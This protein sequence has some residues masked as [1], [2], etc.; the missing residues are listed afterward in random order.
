MWFRSTSQAPVR[1]SDDLNPSGIHS[2]INQVELIESI[3]TVFLVP[4]MARKRIEGHSKTI[5]HAIGKDLLQIPA[6][7]PANESPY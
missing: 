2:P 6:N 3:F 5:A 1:R 4:K 7:F